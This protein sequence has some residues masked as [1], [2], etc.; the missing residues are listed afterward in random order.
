MYDI[1]KIIDRMVQATEAKN[2]AQMLEFMG[3][4]NSAASAWKRRKNIPDGSI[5]KVAERTGVSFEWLKTGEGEMR[6]LYEKQPLLPPELA[7]MVAESLAEWE[8]EKLEMSEGAILL[9]RLYNKMTPEQQRNILIEATS[10]IIA[11]G[12]ELPEE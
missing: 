8:G 4:S 7:E 12:V 10:N 5:A 1:V 11:Q 2:T 6:P 9:V 3:F